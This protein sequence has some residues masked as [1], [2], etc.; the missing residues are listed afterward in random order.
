M[1][2][3]GGSAAPHADAMVITCR[4]RVG[5]M[6]GD[7]RKIAILSA[8]GVAASVLNATPVTAS[9]YATGNRDGSFTI[10]KYDD[11]NPKVH[12]TRRSLAKTIEVEEWR[13]VPSRQSSFA[14]HF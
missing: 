1:A 10:R 11:G 12:I 2:P 5:F 14:R 8:V 7:T 6:G 9:V 4:G 13:E 3:T